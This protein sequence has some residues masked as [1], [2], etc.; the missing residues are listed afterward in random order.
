[1]CVGPQGGPGPH[2]SAGSGYN[3]WNGWGGP[4]GGA[5]GPGG[6]SGPNGDMGYGRGPGA[7]NVGP[8]PA[9]PASAGPGPGPG[10]GPVPV[11]M[12]GANVKTDHYGNNYGNGY[13]SNGGY[14]S[15]SLNFQSFLSVKALLR[16]CNIP[17]F[18]FFLRRMV[19]KA[20]EEMV[21]TRVT[22]THKATEAILKEGHRAMLDLKV[23]YLLI[24][25]N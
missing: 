12:G 23:L 24:Q 8:T 22:V 19:T 18:F 25:E 5:V 7:N 13:G 10:P 14:N 21:T 11:G 1:M 3:N 17:G 6:P 16:H 2:N 20:I 4:Q 15:V 9:G